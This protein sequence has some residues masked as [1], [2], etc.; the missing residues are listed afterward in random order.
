MKPQFG[1]YLPVSTDF[2]LTS[3]KDWTDWST[4]VLST[5]LG[6]SLWGYI[7]KTC[8]CPSKLVIDASTEIKSTIVIVKAT[9]IDHD[10]WIISFIIAFVDRTLREDLL[11]FPTAASLWIH[12]I[13]LFSLV[14]PGSTSFSSSHC[15]PNR[16]I[17]PYR[18]S[19]L[20]CE[21]FGES[22]NS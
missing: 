18:S 8:R 12:L 9:W 10:L 6:H 16:K 4:S 1:Q 15:L 11:Q 13:S 14:V 5:L 17:T 20:K 22:Y 3:A 7:D 19:T 21:N 2:T